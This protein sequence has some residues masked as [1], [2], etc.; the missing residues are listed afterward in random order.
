VSSIKCPSCGHRNLYSTVLR[1]CT[2]CGA[3]LSSPLT[4]SQEPLE[5]SASHQLPKESTALQMSV[6]SAL[7][8]LS[9]K[10]LSV[11]PY[12]IAELPAPADSEDE[13]FQ[14]II[15]DPEESATI[16][17]P[18]MRGQFPRGLP[19]RSP[20]ITGRLIYVQAQTYHSARSDLTGSIATQLFGLI[21]PGSSEQNKE[22]EKVITRM[23]TRAFDGTQSD[24]YLEGMLT[25][26]N[27]ALG[28]EVSLWGHTRKGTLVVHRAYNHTTRSR[29]TTSATTSWGPMLSI[30]I[31]LLVVFVIWTLWSHTPLLPQ[32]PK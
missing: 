24:A 25:G 9:E 26:A 13:L 30:L 5:V 19:R 6:G 21:M 27:V 14:T 20:D 11:E 15:Q 10:D 31:L 23:R 17:L 4:T 29:V 8:R 7:T 18:P 32:W 16:S 22:R 28:D 2:N 1:I 12:Q 3:I